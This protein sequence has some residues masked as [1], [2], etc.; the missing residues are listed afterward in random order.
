V[1]LLLFFH[2]EVDTVKGNSSVVT[3]D[4]STSISIWKTCDDMAVTSLS[5][6]W[7]ISIEYTLVMCLMIFCED[8][9]KFWIWFITIVLA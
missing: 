9:M 6:L 1:I 5:H 7:C 4:T 3:Y 2:K 8:L